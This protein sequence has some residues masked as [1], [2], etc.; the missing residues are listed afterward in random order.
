MMLT[1]KYETEYF[2]FFFFGSNLHP[3]QDLT[4]CISHQ[5]KQKSR[6]Y[7]ITL[8]MY[9]QTTGNDF[10]TK[11]HLRFLMVVGMQ[12]WMYNRISLVVHVI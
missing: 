4:K 6:L 2:N 12:C 1:R 3:S 11:I 7:F 10:R 5:V 8:G 9:A